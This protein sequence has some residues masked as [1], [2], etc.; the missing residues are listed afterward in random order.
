MI[1]RVNATLALHGCGGCSL[2]LNQIIVHI[3]TTRTRL[4]NGSHLD[5]G[6]TLS[7]RT[8]GYRVYRVHRAVQGHN[9][10]KLDY[11]LS[12]NCND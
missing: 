5:N 8:S 11:T 2:S 6:E 7:L 10:S 1:H 4:S 12:E 9:F 3:T